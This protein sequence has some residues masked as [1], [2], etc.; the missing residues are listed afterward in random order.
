MKTINLLKTS[1]KM[2]RSRTGICEAARL[3]VFCVRILRFSHAKI[4][5]SFSWL[6]AKNFK[7]AFRICL[8]CA[9]HFSD[10]TVYFVFLLRNNKIL[11]MFLLTVTVIWCMFLYIVTVSICRNV[12]LSINNSRKIRLRQGT[13]R[14]K[15]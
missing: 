6:S 1:E 8:C 2:I 11:S 7:S 13:L 3:S 4:L 12:Y 5:E 15:P 14:L 10:I 9:Y